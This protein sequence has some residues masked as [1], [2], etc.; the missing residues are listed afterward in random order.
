MS[1]IPL[2][3]KLSENEKRFIVVLFFLIIIVL[4]LLGLIYDG[5]NKFMAAQGK[6]V[7]RLMANQLDSG[8][9]SSLQQFKRNSYKKSR[10]EFYKH[11]R[12]TFLAMIIWFAAYGTVSLLYKHWLDI[13]DQSKE[14]IMTLVY[15]FDFANA[16]TNTFFG[17]TLI[18]DFPPVLH[19]PEFHVEAIP[20]YI[21]FLVAAV[22]VIIFILQVFS[23]LARTIFIMQH[24]KKMFTRDIRDYKLNDLGAAPASIQEKG[25]NTPSVK[26]STP[27][28]TN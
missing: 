12:K 5:L 22:I 3:V 10:I 16:T 27:P 28:E 14:G 26:P 17:I 20:S 21:L 19:H 8:Y 24:S 11:F 9:I 15:T 7:G 18:S 2:L 4:A 23:Y 1:F 13:F 25:V 6:D